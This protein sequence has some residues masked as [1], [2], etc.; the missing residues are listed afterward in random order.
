MWLRARDRVQF[1][2]LELLESAANLE[3]L[4]VTRTEDVASVEVATYEGDRATPADGD[5]AFI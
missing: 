5:D 4:V 3:A 2:R 1:S